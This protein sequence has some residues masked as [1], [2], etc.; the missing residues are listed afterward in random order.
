MNWVRACMAYLGFACPVYCNLALCTQWRENTGK[1]HDLPWQSGWAHRC[2]VEVCIDAGPLCLWVCCLTWL[3]RGLTLAESPG[4][5]DVLLAHITHSSPPEALLR[6]GMAPCFSELQRHRGVQSD[7]SHNNKIIELV[8][9]NVPEVI[10][11]VRKPF[12]NSCSNCALLKRL[13]PCDW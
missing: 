2:Q 6:E 9:I 8:T 10:I 7:H 5:V 4:V 1:A 13:K 3:R 11:N 12:T